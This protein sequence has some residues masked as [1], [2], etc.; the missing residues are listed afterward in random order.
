MKDAVHVSDVAASVSSEEAAEQLRE[1]FADLV[2]RVNMDL[3][4]IRFSPKD[5]ISVEM[6]IAQAERSVDYHLQA[7]TGNTALQALASEIK[8]K[9][10]QGIK[11]QASV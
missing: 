6:A 11:A 3:T 2:L 10:R 8:D 4:S 5:P 7:F 1:D 9:F